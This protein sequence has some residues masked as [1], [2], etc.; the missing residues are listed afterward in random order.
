MTPQ[1][2][3][4]QLYEIF[5]KI[6]PAHPDAHKDE[7]IKQCACEAVNLIMRENEDNDVDRNMLYHEKY[8]YTV[9]EFYEIVKEEINRL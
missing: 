2:K 5:S 9:N 3:A 7:T 1:E 4:K 6:I 8:S